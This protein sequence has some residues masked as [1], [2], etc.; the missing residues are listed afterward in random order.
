MMGHQP[1]KYRGLQ[2]GRCKGYPDFGESTRE[3]F[4]RRA[5]CKVF[6]DED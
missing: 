5:K 2:S 6:R 1:Q 3:E 4:A